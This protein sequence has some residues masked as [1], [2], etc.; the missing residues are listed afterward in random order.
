MCL[1]KYLSHSTPILLS[2]LI[3]R[4]DTYKPN[5]ISD[6]YIFNFQVSTYPHKIIPKHCTKARYRLSMG[7]TSI[8]IDCSSIFITQSSQS[9]KV[10]L[11]N[12]RKF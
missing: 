1:Q 2:L 5:N 12:W 9:T 6:F 11:K 7:L 3:F 8:R 10:K 4:L